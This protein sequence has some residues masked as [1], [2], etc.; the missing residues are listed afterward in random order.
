MWQEEAAGE[1]KSVLHVHLSD[2]SSQHMSRYGHDL[3]HGFILRQHLN[4]SLQV[5]ENKYS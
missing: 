3:E 4:L 5:T 2:F 1:G